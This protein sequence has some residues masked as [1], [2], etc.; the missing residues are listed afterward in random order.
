[1][2]VNSASSNSKNMKEVDGQI[3]PGGGVTDT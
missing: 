3:I 2:V 1:V